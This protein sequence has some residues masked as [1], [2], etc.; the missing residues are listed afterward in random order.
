[1]EQPCPIH[2]IAVGVSPVLEATGP[3]SSMHHHPPLEDEQEVI[4]LLILHHT[5]LHRSSTIFV[6]ELEGVDGCSCLLILGRFLCH[7]QANIDF[8]YK[9]IVTATLVGPIPNELPH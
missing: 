7:D 8:S 2:I 3:P 1:M 4:R 5:H 9:L 6:I